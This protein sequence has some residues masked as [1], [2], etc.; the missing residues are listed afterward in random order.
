MRFSLLFW[1]CTY[2]S[3]DG[4]TP[5]AK[6]KQILAITPILGGQRPD[7][8]SQNPPKQHTQAQP[9]VQQAQAPPQQ[10]QDHQTYPP[11]QQAQAPAQ[12]TQMPPPQVQ[13]LPQHAQVPPQHI[14]A[15]PMNAQ[16]QQARAEP[17]PMSPQ[18]HQVPTPIPQASAQ[19]QQVP[20]LAHRT[21]ASD[22][23]D[24]GQEPQ[25]DAVPAPAPMYQQPMASHDPPAGLQEPLEPA[26]G[27]PIVRLDTKTEEIDVFVDAP[28]QKH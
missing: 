17:Q 19:A 16:F 7:Q 5:E 15:A 10:A 24:F 28:D 14:Q 23:I 21:A 3:S 25:G 8:Q 1:N 11:L 2:A 13:A 26:L 4:P 27:P 22:L 9:Q 20:P 6:I 18:V 12:Q